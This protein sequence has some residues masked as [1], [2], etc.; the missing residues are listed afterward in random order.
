M[1]NS[2]IIKALRPKE[3]RYQVTDSDGLAL[4]IQTSG[5]KSWV[6]RV[7]QNGR[8]V[9]ITL[10]HWPELSLMQ[11]RATARR[12]KK[13]L[14]LEPSGSYM[15]RDAFKFWCSKKKGR[16]ISYRDEK[17]RLEKY[18]ISKIGSRQLDTITP[19]I[20]IKLMEPI[21]QAGKQSTVKRLL[22]RT[23]E[24]FDMAVNAGYLPSNPLAK[25]TKVFAVPTV[26]HMASVDWKELPIVVSQIESLAPP[27]YKNL[28]YFSLATLLR[29]GEVVSIRLD[30]INEEAITI[31]AEFMKMKRVHR[32]P[33]TPYL[34]ALIQEAKTIRKNK[35]SPYL[36]PGT[37]PNKHI[38]GQALAKWLHSQTEFKNRLVAHGLRSIGRT[39]F[40]DNDVPLEVAE[41]C[42]AHVTGSQVVRA[43][44][45]GDYFASRSKILLGWHAYIQTCARC[46]QVLS[47]NPD[48]SEVSA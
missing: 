23:R 39:W 12:K 28:F 10:G 37:R 25:I 21:E 17:L 18:V 22:M 29:P 33:L 32:I 42:L 3:R 14:E 11:A 44:Q 31:P 7:F 30:W 9:D 16:I 8:I 5:V 46:A 6:L 38:S 19:P 26:K 27:K 43:Y 45:R 35:R 34:I 41:A 48:K 2:K 36:F 20:L 47:Q 1:L 15:V 40:A 4:R 24:I 13:E